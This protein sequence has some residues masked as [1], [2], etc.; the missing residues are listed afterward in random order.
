MSRAASLVDTS[1]V[2]GV[3]MNEVCCCVK[4]LEDL[5]GN[6]GDGAIGAIH[7]DV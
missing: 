5:I 6:D 7:G 4:A 1:A 2:G 3:G